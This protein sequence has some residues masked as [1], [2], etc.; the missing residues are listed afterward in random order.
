[1]PNHRYTYSVLALF[2]AA[3]AACSHDST[4]T[5]PPD[6][7]PPPV[8]RLKDVVIPH[9][10]SPYYHFA[11]DD[12]GRID[13]VS[14]ASEFTNYDVRYASGR[15][16]E[17][18]NNIFVNQDRLVYV[19]DDAARVREVDYTDQTGAVFTRVHLTYNGSK[20]ITLVRERLHD[21]VFLVDK[22]MTFAYGSDG[23]LSA[24]SNHRPAIEGFQPDVSYTDHF[25]DYDEGVNVDA[26]GL[27]HDDFFDHLVLLPTVQL[28]KN[29]PRRITRTGDVDNF[30]VEYTYTYDASNRPLAKAGDLVYQTGPHAGQHFEDS[31]TYSYYD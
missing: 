29:N 13:S 10:P 16:T 3:V 25:D 5:G 15:I 23:N 12:A 7:P 24:L 31:A 22:M 2:L 30:L 4:L 18:H 27:L 11:Y 6:P 19:Y 20:L 9:L 1:M 26:F 17:L 14:F 8:V 28:Q 21:N